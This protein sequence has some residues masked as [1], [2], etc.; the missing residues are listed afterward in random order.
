MENPWIDPAMIEEA[1]N[2]L[3]A[4]AFAQEYMATWETYEG[5]AYYN[6]DES[7]HV[8]ECGNFDP[9]LPVSIA[10]DFNVNPTTLLVTSYRQGRKFIHREY[11]FADSSTE[12]TIKAFIDDFKVKPSHLPVQIR[13]D[14]AGNQRKSTTGKSDYAYIIEAMKNSGIPHI[15][16]VPSVNPPIIDRV[17][18]VNGWLRPLIG[19]PRIVIDPSCKHLIKDLAGQKLDGRIPSGNNNLGHKADALGYDI[20]WESLAEKRIQSSCKRI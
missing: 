9:S 13:G 14:S 10:L 20:Y 12:R 1:M 5:L 4:K 16:Q 17:N 11:S 2:D 19:I 15:F 3:D 18:I 8:K 6:F 7:L